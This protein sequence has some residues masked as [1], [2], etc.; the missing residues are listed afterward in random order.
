M[1]KRAAHSDDKIPC[2]ARSG[3]PLFTQNHGNE[4]W[5]ML[6]EKAFAKFVGSCVARAAA[7]AASPLPRR[8]NA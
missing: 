4:M 7:A 8:R 1:M 3:K 6:M 5:V 2:S